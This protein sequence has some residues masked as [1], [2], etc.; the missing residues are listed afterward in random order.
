MNIKILGG[1]VIDPASG[2]NQVADVWIKNGK[3]AAIVPPGEGET[4]CAEERRID[5]S[6]LVVAPGLVDLHVHLR[7]PGD[8]HKED[9]DSG[10]RAAVAGGVTSLACMPNT[11]PALDSLD[12]YRELSEAI[13]RA[14]CHVYPVA[15]VT[16]GQMGQALS[17][18][19]ALK[20]AG[21][22]AV[23][24]DGR[25]VND[26]AL[27]TE[28]L[29]LAHACGLLFIDHCEPETEQVQRD[30]ELC[31]ETGAPVHLAHLSRKASLA[32]VREAKRDGLPVT[33][34]TCPH[35]FW[36]T[37]D[38]IARVGTNAKMN[39]PLSTAE[40]R[41]S[42]L[43]ALYD[44]TIDIITTDHAPHAPAEKLRA[45]DDAP[46][47]VIG[48]ET[49]LSA[50]LT[51]LYHTGRLTLPELLARLSTRPA[52]LLGVPAGRLA[53]GEAA[54]L[55]VFDPD[56]SVVPRAEQMHSKSRNTPFDGVPLRGQI[57]NVFVAG[58]ML[59]DN[60]AVVI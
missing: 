2:Y 17:D 54:D 35:Y 43:E 32:L 59:V 42:V 27:M 16:Q 45:F 14:R 33:C 28:A 31:R 13:S 3:I 9:I 39:P 5:A 53:A 7:E 38:E 49:L 6:G 21:I 4:P 41:E 47:G 50:S 11:R 58:K 8:T 12:T 34:E 24:D 40:D 25:P 36:F 48:L 15:A 30:I 55:V 20:K 57:K 56:A 22:M 23:S 37:Q 29:R 19:A 46:N 26:R 60:G 51:A 44:G 1:R 18:F 10:T 52:Q